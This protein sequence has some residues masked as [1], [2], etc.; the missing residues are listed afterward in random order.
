MLAPPA[1]PA[2]DIEGAGARARVRAN[3]SVTDSDS[4]VI[5]R[6][7]GRVVADFRDAWL[8]DACGPSPRSLWDARIP[9][10]DTVPGANRALWIAWCVYNH[11]A[12]LALFPLMFAFWLIAHPGHLLYAAPVAVPLTLIWLT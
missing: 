8:W 1:S 2:D 4:T 3:D 9:D 6:V 5:R 11:A 7:A 12:L 10:L